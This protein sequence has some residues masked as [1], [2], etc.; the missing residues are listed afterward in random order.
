MFVN[1]PTSEG[2]D[3]ATLSLSG[4]Q[5]DLVS[6]VAAANPR[7]IVVL[8]TGGPAAMPWIDSVGAAIEIW[9]PGIRGAEALANILF[10]DVNPFGE[11]AGHVPEVR[12]RSASPRDLR[13]GPGCRPARRPLGAA[14]GSTAAMPMAPF[15][16]DYTEGLKVGYKWF[17][18]ENKAAAVR[19]RPRALVHDVR[20]LGP[21]GD[22]RLGVVHRAQHGE[23]RRG[24]D[25]TGLRRASRRRQRAA[26]ASGRVGEDPAG[27]RVRPRPSR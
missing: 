13:V 21:E 9:Y 12:G 7:T 14:G 10:G 17:Q 19:L 8:E 15:D 3:L 22:D 23:A 2:R 6:A 18:A 5:N 11:A 24:G 26:E 16:I 1:E 27:A 25:R 4:T 20:L